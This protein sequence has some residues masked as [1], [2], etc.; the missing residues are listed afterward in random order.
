VSLP[1]ILL[2]TSNA[3]GVAHRIREALGGAEL[4]GYAPRVEAVDVTFTDLEMQLA[5]LF[6]GGRPIIGICAA[7]ILIRKLAPLLD[8]KRAEPPVICASALASTSRP[9]A[10][11]WATPTWPNASWRACSRASRSGSRSMR[12]ATTRIG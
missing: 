2:L 4:F 10:G 6:E 9:Q 1:G 11:A 3:L 5:E 12:R 8:D 7:G